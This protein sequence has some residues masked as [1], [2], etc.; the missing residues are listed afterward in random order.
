[1][2]LL[3]TAYNLLS[4]VDAARRTGRG[5]RYAK[6]AQRR[7]RTMCPYELSLVVTSSSSKQP[8]PEKQQHP[9]SFLRCPF[10]A[11]ASADAARSIQRH[12]KK[13]SGLGWPLTARGSQSSHEI[14]RC[15]S[16]LCSRRCCY[17]AR[18]R[19]AHGLVAGS[20]LRPGGRGEHAR[21]RA[22]YIDVAL[23]G[24]KAAAPCSKAPSSC[25][26]PAAKRRVQ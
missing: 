9:G 6:E 4:S 24:S 2:R 23:G 17:T 12:K 18:A 11:V 25:V 15:A 3:G 21:L 20:A 19:T 1:M 26:E 14:A 5:A 10:V 13:C 22:A 8:R 7:L 16:P